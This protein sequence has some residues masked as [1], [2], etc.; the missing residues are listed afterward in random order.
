[1]LI[2]GN[3]GDRIVVASERC[4]TQTDDE[5]RRLGGW[6]RNVSVGVD[7]CSPEIRCC[8]GRR[9]GQVLIGKN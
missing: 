2:V 6:L 7:K 8:E 5:V 1:M 9:R 4:A 3:E